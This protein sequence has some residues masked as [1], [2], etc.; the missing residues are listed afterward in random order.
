MKVVYYKEFSK[1]LNRDIEFKVYGHRGKPCLFFPS[2]S[3]KFY[4]YEDRG[5]I[6]SLSNLIEEGKIQIFTVDSNDNESFSANNKNPR[7][8]ILSQEAYYNYIIDEMVPRIYEINSYNNYGQSN[9]ILSYGVSLGAYHA[10][11]V[12]IRRP[13]IFDSVIALSGIYNTNYYISNYADEYTF[14]NSP[15][16]SLKHLSFDHPY[17][18]LYKR[19]KIIVCVGQGSWEEDCLQDTRKI[20][21]Q[22]ERLSIPAWIDYWGYDVPHDWP[23]WLLQTPYFFSH[24]L[25]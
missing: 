6:S 1:Y 20:Q 10:M 21:G 4:D 14:L 18:N 5:I 11:N 25:N 9:K 7:D 15:I 2:Q 13:D 23:S 3:G 8:R 12:F 19:S 17:V 24:V 16:E 22:F